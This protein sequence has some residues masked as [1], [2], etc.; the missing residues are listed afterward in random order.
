M[1][2]K[3]LKVLSVV[4]M[5]GIGPSA[6]V[7]PIMLAEGGIGGTGISYGPISGFGSIYVN[8]ARYDLDVAE[9][10]I[11]GQPATEA[12]LQPGMMVRVYGDL[13]DSGEEGV[14]HRVEFNY[15]LR[16]VEVLTVNQGQ[17]SFVAGGQL[18]T[19]D[20]L[21]VFDGSSFSDLQVG[22]WV[23]VSGQRVAGD[24]FAARYVIVQIAPELEEKASSTVGSGGDIGSPNVEADPVAVP[25]KTVVEGE[26]SDLNTQAK[27]FRMGSL[28]VSFATLD[29]H[30]PSISNGDWLSVRGTLY[31]GL[32]T[33][34]RLDSTAF[35]VMADAGSLLNVSGYIQSLGQES[36]RVQGVGVQLT[37]ATGYVN[38]QRADLNLG[39]RVLV[40][41][42]VARNG[43]VVAEK[44]HCVRRA[45][46]KVYARVSGIDG[47]Q[48]TLNGVA[49]KVNRSTLM[50]DHSD[51]KARPF[52]VA[53]LQI[54][55]A[56][57]VSGYETEHGMVISRLQRENDVSA[58]VIKASARDVFQKMGSFNLLN[59]PITLA[60]QSAGVQF[61][62]G[63]SSV[64]QNEFFSSL[65]EGIKVEAWGG[66]DGS[67]FTATKLMLID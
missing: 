10:I 45:E 38:C 40:V 43:M 51:A 23:S 25:T 31:K 28:L 65:K 61:W 56:L 39:H 27:T 20:E 55:D 4:F 3:V 21:T 67:S 12:A 63:G 49:A 52:G 19:T 17:G 13:D 24:E 22:E 47:D 48:L 66:W 1:C 64:S 6:C 62:S 14:A 29:S 35:D 32:L 18:V 42:R 59:I 41:G 26:V 11:E 60:V 54:G 44:L 5:L 9:V 57:I 34:S 50:L 58:R 37:S 46:V 8:G 15:D 53:Q 30:E 36:L 2:S 33:A 7:E 16:Y